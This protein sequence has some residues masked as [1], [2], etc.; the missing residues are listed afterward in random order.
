M[1]NIIELIISNSR[2]SDVV[3]EYEANG[4]TLLSA[5]PVDKNN[6]LVSFEGDSSS[7]NSLIYENI[8]KAYIKFEDGVI[9]PLYIKKERNFWED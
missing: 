8:D 4:F 1:N 7:L 9:A 5:K 3:Q 6:L 2:Y